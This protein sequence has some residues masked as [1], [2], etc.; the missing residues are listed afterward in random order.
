MTISLKSN[1]IKPNVSIH[2]ALMH[3]ALSMIWQSFHVLVHCLAPS[4]APASA[5]HPFSSQFQAAPPI[6]LQVD[7][8]P[9]SL[10]SKLPVTDS[11]MNPP[12]LLHF[13][14]SM[15]L[16]LTGLHAEPPCFF[17]RHSTHPCPIPC[18]PAS[19]ISTTLL[20]ALGQYLRTYS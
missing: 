6:L 17:I 18:R 8:P 15:P 13:C 5:D 9:L 10:P 16:Q 7:L 12:R 3:P 11:L 2:L 4:L 14:R 19:P 1:Q 20:A